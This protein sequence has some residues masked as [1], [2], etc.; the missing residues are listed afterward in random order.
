[1]HPTGC[2]TR[3]EVGHLRRR[4]IAIQHP[5]ETSHDAVHERNCRGFHATN[6]GKKP[7]D[8]RELGL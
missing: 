6:A 3:V 7:F 8:R 2:D 5:Q 4:A 1:M